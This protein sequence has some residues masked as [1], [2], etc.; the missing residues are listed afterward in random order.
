[1]ADHDDELDQQTSEEYEDEYEDEYDDAVDEDADGGEVDIQRLSPD[2]QLE[3]FSKRPLAP[4]FILAFVVHVAVIGL[5]SIPWLINY[6]NPAAAEEV[7]ELEEVAEQATSS[8]E[9]DE[10]SEVAPD[11]EPQGADRGEES[12]RTDDLREDPR[13][14]NPE[15]V[16]QLQQ[17]ETPPDDLLDDVGDR[18]RMPD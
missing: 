10:V 17:A 13:V 12:S 9:P 16:E 11:P 8:A 14:R 2:R 4:V 6:F 3:G 1:M 7:E 18:L 5:T 15:Y